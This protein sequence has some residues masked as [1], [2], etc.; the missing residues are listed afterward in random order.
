MRRLLWCPLLVLV[1]SLV[2]MVCRPDDGFRSDYPKGLPCECD[3]VPV[4]YEFDGWYD[5]KEECEQ[6]AAVDSTYGLAWDQAKS[7]CDTWYDCTD[8]RCPQKI[9]RAPAKEDACECQQAKDGPN[10]GRW[11]LIC[12]LVYAAECCCEPE[13]EP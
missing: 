4:G 5:S 3:N 6:K 9:L 12:D 1:F 7:F 8:P 10:K 13:L 11:A 2:A